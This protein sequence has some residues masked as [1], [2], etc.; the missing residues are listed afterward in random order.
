MGRVT[1]YI[2]Q[3][4]PFC[5]KVQALLSQRVA[6]AVECEQEVDATRPKSIHEP[7]PKPALEIL[8]LDVGRDAAL[9]AQCIRLT[10]KRTVPQ[11]F[12]NDKF[13]G[14]FRQTSKLNSTGALLEELRQASRSS[15]SFPPEAEAAMVKVTMSSRSPPCQR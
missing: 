10:N 9:A 5:D 3:Q 15:T 2:R 8:F 11:V 13:I 4:C 12:V 1:V 14:N 7:P 6:Q